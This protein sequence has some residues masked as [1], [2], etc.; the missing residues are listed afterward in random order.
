MARKKKVKEDILITG[1]ADKGMGVGRDE[2]GMVYFVEGPV[3]GDVVDVLVLRKKS[4]YRKGVVQ[5]YKELSPE[6]VEAKCKHFGACGGCK[7]QNL[8]YSSQLKYKEQSVKD[9]FKRIAHIE[10]EDFQDIVGCDEIYSY[11][12]KMEYSFSYRRWATREELDS[13][14]DI[15]F[16]QAVGFHR[17]GSF[18]KVVQIDQC[19]LQ[20]DLSNRL[21]NFVHAFALERNWTYYN[22]REHHGFLRNMRVRNTSL[23]EWM[24]VM[25]FGENKPDEIKEILEALKDE[26]PQLNSIQY[27]INTKMNDS[28]HDLDAIHYW[29]E[30][31]IT[32]ALGHLKYNIGP[33]SFFQTNSK[34]ALKLYELVRELADLKG[35]ETVYDLY[36]GLGSIALFIAEHCKKVVGIEEI[37]EAIDDA[38]ANKQLNEIDNAYF[39]VGDVRKEF[40]DSF[41]NKYGYAELIIVDPPRAGLQSEVCDTINQS[42][43]DRVIYVSCNP[44]TQAR[45]IVLMD[46]YA[47]KL[48]KP[49][50]MFPHTHHIENVALLERI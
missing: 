29:G 25:I 48:L 50:D 20:D 41:R 36:T 23:G 28:V 32:E 39:E 45:D 44:S 7:W 33:K 15:D 2:E 22:S 5:Q 16:G 11:R 3:P 17:A 49:V 46:N 26:F 37:K 42:G 18:D 12:N 27:I 30:K 21:R 1:I 10:A 43:A 8:D 34:Q 38:E 14:K 35:H 19:Q 13:G 6:R 24:I 40:N 4:S 9:A 31:H 47:V